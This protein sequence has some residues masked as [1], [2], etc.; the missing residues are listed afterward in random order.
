MLRDNQQQQSTD[1]QRKS[2][3]EKVIEDEAD[4][5]GP[6]PAIYITDNLTK[7][8]TT[9]PYKAR[10]AKHEGHIADTWVYDCKVLIKDNRSRIYQIE[11]Q[12]EL[13]SHKALR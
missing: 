10:I 3:D 6:L 13:N 8:R 2:V 12:E 4:D 7:F 1:K 9:L 5:E 11:S